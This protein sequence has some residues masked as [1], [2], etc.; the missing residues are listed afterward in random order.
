MAEHKD[1]RGILSRREVLSWALYDWANS[2]FA[3]T[4]MAGFF[5]VFFKEYWSAG[6]DATVSTFRLGSANSI[7]GLAVALLAPL[8]G[9]MADSGGA[10]KRFLFF[11]VLVG[12]AM[13]GSLCLVGRGLWGLAA[14]GYIFAVIGFSAGNIFYD[15]LIVDVA[16][17]KE[18]DFVS[19]LGYSVGYLGGGL[20][21]LLNVAMTLKPSLFGLSSA[22]EAVRLSFLTVALWWALFSVPIFLYVRE[23][24]GR[25]ARLGWAAARA[26][27]RQLVD[28]FHHLR[29]LKVVMTFLVGYWLY[30]DGVHTIIRMA[31]DYGLSLGFEANSLIVALLITQFVGFPAALAFGKIGERIGTKRAIFIGIAVYGGITLWGYFMDRVFE[32]YALA[33]AVGLVQGGVQSLS[34]S[35]YARI[36]PRDKSAEFFGFYN[37]VGRF[38]AIIG[39]FLMGW[40]G[41][42]TGSSRLSILSILALFVAGGIVFFTVDEGEGLRLA[43]E[44]EGG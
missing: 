17:P 23:S 33:V 4:V 43:R 14:A 3:T 1:A 6:V 38:A 25:A 26:G 15:S 39:P 28:T 20:L 31:V 24:G 34:R 5:P 9:A 30:I 42:A 16:G 2:A 21:F 19:A 10:K 36:I 29:S 18:M 41:A 27:V 44:L 35:F 22:K 12:V 11:F 32:F 7:A 13:T 40:V 37:M 8:L